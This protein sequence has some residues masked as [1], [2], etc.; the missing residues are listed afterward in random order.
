MDDDMKKILYLLG[1]ETRNIREEIYDLPKEGLDTKEIVDKVEK[2]IYDKGFSSAFP[3]TVCI[4]EVAAHFTPFKEGEILKKGDVLKVDFGLYY[5]G[6]ISDNAFTV[7]VGTN[8]YSK[9][10]ET[11]MKALNNAIENIEVGSTMDQLGEI[12]ENT[13]AENNFNTIH[14]LRGH[15]IGVDDLHCGINV[16]NYKNNDKKQVEENMEIAIEPFLTTGEPK[17]KGTGPSN[18]LSLISEKPTRDPIARKLLKEIREK[19]SK[20]PFAKRWLLE[21]FDERK[22]SYGLNVL[23]REGIVFEYEALSS[24]DNSVIAQFEDTVIFDE[25]NKEII[26]RLK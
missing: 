12:V 8:N 2:L 5:N 4:N 18:I 15:Q 11:T 24:T 6:Y 10:L 20:M 13:A 17:V 1:K 23:K 3:C 7:E 26:T 14:N 19:Y 16:P 22:I 25:K 21:N 9:L